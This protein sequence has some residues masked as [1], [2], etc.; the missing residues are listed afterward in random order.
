VIAPLDVRDL[1]VCKAQLL[2]RNHDLL[3]SIHKHNERGEICK[4]A[5]LNAVPAS[6]FSLVASFLSSSVISCRLSF[7]TEG[8]G[9][10][11]SDGVVAGDSSDTGVDE[12][13]SLMM[14]SR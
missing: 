13:E 12:D 4:H 5:L 7:S 9:G 11:V 1:L 14:G 2:S 6:T 8:E 3:S 10:T